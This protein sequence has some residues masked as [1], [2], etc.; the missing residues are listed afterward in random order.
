MAG[1]GKKSEIL[2][3]PAEGVP[4]KVGRGKAVLWKGVLG[5]GCPV[6]CGEGSGGSGQSKHWP[7][8][9]IGPKTLIL[10]K[11]A[12]NVGDGLA[13]LMATHGLA[14]LGFCHRWHGQN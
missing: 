5:R 11:L 8:T 13:N 2:G 6:C 7:N 4:G 10:V 14:K 9:E 3:R 1:S 12:K